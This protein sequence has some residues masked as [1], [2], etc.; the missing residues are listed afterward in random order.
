MAS[1]T[2]MSIA[3]SIAASIDPLRN[4]GF[5]SRG[6]R[7]YV[8]GSLTLVFALNSIDRLLLGVIAQP[9]IEEFQM[10]DWEFGL[11]SGIGFALMYTLAGIPIA[12]LAERMNRVRI[13]AACTIIWS[14]MT[15]ACGF[16][17]GFAS[18]LIFRIG[19]GIGEAGC[20]PPATSLLGDYFIPRARARALA[21]Y[22][23]GL[24]FGGLV[25]NLAGGPIAQEL[26]WRYAFFIL[27]A[28][29]IL[30]GMVIWFTVKE[31]PRG[32]SDPVSVAKPI[33]RSFGKT[34]AALAPKKSYWL[35]L[36]AV[37]LSNSYTSSLAS[38]QAPFYQRTHGVS[39]SEVAV[40][41]IVPYSIAA[42]LS[43]V[44]AGYLTERL[45]PRYPNSVAWIPA[46][47]ILLPLPLYLIAFNTADVQIARAAL[48]GAGLLHYSYLGAQYTIAQGLAD[49]RSRATAIAIFLLIT[50][51][52]SSIGPV[53]TGL[54][55]DM[56]ATYQIEIS[57]F[58]VQ[59]TLTGCKNTFEVISQKLGFGQA[60]ACAEATRLGLQKAL[61]YL[62]FL[63]IP[64]SLAM[65]AICK[66]LQHD[67][68]ARMN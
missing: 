56:V 35:L 12:R 2:D 20:T 61:T 53:T 28:P 38:F 67:L 58:S 48:V 33:Y 64:S 49:A 5:G 37:I 6:Y 24:A 29:G 21:I 22:G 44:I 62:S 40:Q 34:L 23:V 11:L 9:L 51:L 43:A 50:T 27:G 36:T 15:V 46:I 8:L 16:A 65:F 3:P 7:N 26:G 60:E 66:T 10:S 17:T 1:E 32:Y 19:V 47:G 59:L 68:V 14:V 63:C 52:V 39:V 57:P 25:A 45:S 31:P 42:M 18:L 41:F 4:A 30:V 13:I 55:S 54:V